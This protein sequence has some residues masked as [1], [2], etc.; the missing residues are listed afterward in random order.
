MNICD[1]SDSHRREA[2]GNRVFVFGALLEIAK[3]RLD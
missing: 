1:G 3:Q 2:N